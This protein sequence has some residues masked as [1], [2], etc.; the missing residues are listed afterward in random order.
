MKPKPKPEVFDIWE[1]DTPERRRP[2]TALLAPKMALPTHAESF[3]PP[4]EYLFTEREKQE[5]E[6]MDESERPTSFIPQ[7]YG[8]LRKVPAYP[9]FITE[10]FERCLD[11][12]LVPR[13]LKKRMNVDKESL[14]P[15][16]P[17][18]ADLR[19]F[20]MRVSVKFEGHTKLIRTMSIDCSGRFLA[21]GSDD[22]YCLV[23]C[24]R[25]GRPV[26]RLKLG[27]ACQSVAF[28]PTD[29]NVLAV[30]SESDL[31]ILNLGLHQSWASATDEFLCLPEEAIVQKSLGK[32]G[33]RKTDDVKEARE[34]GVRLPAGNEV[35]PQNTVPGDDDPEG[36]SNFKKSLLKEVVW[37]PVLPASSSKASSSSSKPPVDVQ[38]RSALLYE[39]GARI[40]IEHDGLVKQLEWHKSGNYLS[41]V[42]VN[43][44][45]KA[46][47][48]IIHALA[49]KKSIKP[50][51]KLKTG[52][53]VTI[54][55]TSFHPTKAHFFVATQ[56]SIRVFHLQKLTLV[57]QM[58]AGARWISSM[59]VHPDG[60][61]LIVGTLDR[62]L[63]WFD[64]ELGKHAYKTFKY[65]ERGVRQVA[66]YGKVAPHAMEVG[67]SSSSSS[68]AAQ[69]PEE[70]AGASSSCQT[71]GKKLPS[72][73]YPLMCTASDDG[74]VHVFHARVYKDLMT[75][76]LIVPVKKL[77]GHERRGNYGVMDCVW[78][79]S[80]PWVF[81]AGADGKALLWV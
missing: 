65:H 19:P 56:R 16:L 77:A 3:N 71:S 21:T 57:K 53:G 72:T 7:K 67:G 35:A 1:E 79:P 4:A 48:C 64:L 26:R 15:K 68:A 81:T 11:L 43:C 38:K 30:A 24:V 17:S 46:N 14:L 18:P 33:E 51:G 28:S 5:W 13:A 31:Y 29:V 59:S 63:M 22:G 27:H 9:K 34:E 74:T 70:E 78:H 2:P 45:S 41:A 62:C 47:Q 49:T 20:P 8:S 55:A 80:Q 12:Y 25:T 10:R 52:S 23:W 54:Q 50:F 58:N 37:R 39:K 76:P 44:S 61:H 69:K 66:F 42:A 75:N 32:E 73:H 40:H 36:P 60:D 6:E